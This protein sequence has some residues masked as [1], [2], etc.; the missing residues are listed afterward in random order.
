MRTYGFKPIRNAIFMGVLFTSFVTGTALG[1]VNVGVNLNIGP[2]PIVAPAPPEVV[3]MPNFG[4]YFVPG[5]EFDVFFHNGF[6]W[7][8]RGDRW[9]RSQEY[10]GPWR[11][12]ERRYVPGPVIR[13]PRDY[14]GR[15][16]RERH[17]PYGEWRERHFR[18]EHH[19]MR[20]HERG[21]HREHDRGHEHER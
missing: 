3:L 17:I 4:V 7:S 21:E 5:L 19:E 9:Y 15:F 6:W 10:G 11:V 2:P 13:V 12:V 18:D 8:P 20:E 1:G 14:R 16:V